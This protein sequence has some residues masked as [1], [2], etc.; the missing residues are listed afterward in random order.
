MRSYPQGDVYAALGRVLA[1]PD[2]VGQMSGAEAE[3]S[4]KLVEETPRR[5]R[6][7]ILRDFKLALAIG[8]GSLLEV[9]QDRAR[10]VDPYDN[11]LGNRRGASPLQGQG[12]G[13]GALSGHNLLGHPDGRDARLPS[14]GK[15]RRRRG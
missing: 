8:D 11:R 4:D 10:G 15:P 3:K 9:D 14:D 5:S 2:Q 7:E 1:Q 12:H 13:Q 6:E